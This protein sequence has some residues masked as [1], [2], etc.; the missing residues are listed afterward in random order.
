MDA[1]NYNLATQY[2]DSFSSLIDPKK[3]VVIKADLNNPS[4]IT[5]DSMELLKDLELPSKSAK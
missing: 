5:K 4:S 2:I 3:N 1:A